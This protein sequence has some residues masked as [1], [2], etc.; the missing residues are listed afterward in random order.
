MDNNPN[1]DVIKPSENHNSNQNSLNEEKK[2]IKTKKPI[3]KK[4]IFLIIGLIVI[5]IIVFIFINKPQSNNNSSSNKD[6][7][8]PNTQTINTEYDWANKYGEYLLNNYKDYDT[9]DIAFADLDDNKTPELIVKYSLN[10]RNVYEIL[11]ISQNQIK[12]TR[13]YNNADFYL[14][15]PLIKKDIAWYIYIGD[16][17]YGTYTILSELIAGTALDSTI[18]ATNNTEVNNYLKNY[19]SSPFKLTFYE[20]EK[21]NFMDD[22]LKKVNKY[23][24]DSNAIQKAIAELSDNYDQYI[25]EH[26][27]VTGQNYLSLTSFKLDFG[28]YIGHTFHTVE[29]KVVSEE[30]SLEIIDNNIIKKDNE[31]LTFTITG[32]TIICSNGLQLNVIG[33]NQFEIKDENDITTTYN[34]F[35]PTEESVIENTEES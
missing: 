13:N 10:N 22:Y 34:L 4:L 5:F 17:N 32:N 33:N 19:L 12:K 20:I 2:L 1:L 21:K 7:D 18:K 25:L 23:E 3:N 27:P 31:E 11:S 15:T 16:T 24:S 8:S 28:P 6:K 14:I 26:G 35:I 30:V 9:Y 29:D